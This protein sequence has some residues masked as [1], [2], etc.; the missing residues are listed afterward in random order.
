MSTTAIAQSLPTG[1]WKLDPVHSSIG[2]E[3]DYMVGAFRGSFGDVDARLEDGRLTGS[4]RVDSI[5]VKDENLAAHL[6]TPDFF[7][8]AEHPALRFES[9]EITRGG[10]ELAVHGKLTLK[11]VTRPVVLKGTIV[12]P[13]TDAYG[14]ERIG[15]TL[16]T[17][18]DRTE[19]G[20]DWNMPL[21]S[22]DPALANEVRLFA[23]LYLVREA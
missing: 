23:D 16:Q 15:L 11:G 12:D 5:D 2:F 8:A 10:N 18:L 1:T 7:D 4:A 19:F 3:V 6:Q 14:N 17:A 22:G 21:P 20:I 9:T 13:I